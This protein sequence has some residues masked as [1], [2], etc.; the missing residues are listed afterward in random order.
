MEMSEVLILLANNGS[1]W[2]ASVVI[3][4][5]AVLC[6]YNIIQ[7]TFDNKKQASALNEVIEIEREARKRVTEELNQATEDLR[8][9]R[10]SMRALQKELE[11]CYGGKTNE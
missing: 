4:I 6:G 8:E 7:Q 3:G 1:S 2:L 11:R 9:L 10:E 5:V